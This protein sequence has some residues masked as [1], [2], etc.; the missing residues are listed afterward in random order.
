[1]LPTFLGIGAMRGGTS[2]L[3]QLLASHPDIYVPARRKE[4]CFFD[5]YYERGFQWYEKFFP[6]EVEAE[7]YRAIGEI[8]PGYIRSSLSLERI[9]RV[10]SITKLI[11]TIRNPIDR[12]YSH[13]GLVVR[14]GKTSESFEAFLSSEPEAIQWGFYSQYLKNYL[15]HFDRDQILV[16]VFEHMIAD[17]RQA[18][19]T[20]A[21][22]L[23]VS[24]DRFPE[25]A[26][27]K[28]VFSSYVPK[29]ASAY[30]LSEHVVYR[31]IEW[32]MDWVVNL[33]NRIGINRKR[34]FGVGG[35]LPPMEEGTRQY[36]SKIYEK[37]IEKLEL[38]LQIDLDCWR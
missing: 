2:W 21:S 35:S 29:V 32:D 38:L 4:V 18:K 8:S 15:R 26:G 28:Q 11:L 5:K 12:A 37:E 31:L 6:D 16:L 25:W 20:L 3:H 10:P 17:V 13:Y 7:R 30:A 23:D 33:A 19:E 9:I 27:T 22:F 34:L 36:L 14:L 24:A 1:M